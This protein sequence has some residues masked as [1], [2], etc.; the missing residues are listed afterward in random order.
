MTFAT[1]QA[2]RAEF[3]NAK[4]HMKEML[5]IHAEDKTVETAKWL[6]I[7]KQNY[8][9]LK[10]ELGMTEPKEIE[11]YGISIDCDGKRYL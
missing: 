4:E 8:N 5:K 7:A 2:K 6:E 3:F 9:R 10:N 1:K 11:G